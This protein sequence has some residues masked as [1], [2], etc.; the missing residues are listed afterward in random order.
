MDDKKLNQKDQ[1]EKEGKSSE[2]SNK[3][4]RKK[5]LWSILAVVLV[6][7]AGAS[8][9]YFTY[10]RNYFTTDN[11]KVTAKMYTITPYTSGEL[12]EWKIQEGQKV[13]KHE[14]LGRQASLPYIVS[15]IDGT[16]V[17]NN[18]TEGQIVSPGTALAVVADTGNMYIG[19]NIEETEIMKVK[20]GQEVDVKIDAY[21]GRTFPG[22]IEEIDQ[23]TQ[24]YLSNPTSF[25]T[26]GTYTKVTQLIP[27]KVVIENKENLPLTFGMNATVKIH[28]RDKVTQNTPENKSTQEIAAGS[29]LEYSSFIEAADQFEISPDVSGK[30]LSVAVELGQKVNKGDVL[31]KLDSADLAL[32]VQQAAEAAA[33]ARLAYNDAAATYSRLQTLYDAG[34]IAKVDLDNARTRMETAKAQLNSAAT[35]LQIVQ[36]KLNDCTVTAPISG[37]IASLK[38]AEGDMVSPQM[39]AMTLIDAK[40]VIV[41]I[42]VTET[43][44]SRVKIGTKVQ[45]DVQ[46]INASAEGKVVSIAPASDSETGMFPVE[47]RFDNAKGI[48]KP[49]M[50]AN[51]KLLL[52]PVN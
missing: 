27:V 11:A 3:K 30:V 52:D 2:G 8:F 42:N 7:A 46:A 49:G 29:G 25:S 14:I 18:V 10:S 34:A 1:Q 5:I 37:E 6:I 31:F 48:F 36:K 43:N 35:A 24:T 13:A 28:L 21:P 4:L 51:V 44:I 47:I 32:Q 45:I 15:P 12:L 17:K 20:T 39:P 16:I 33:P 41:H 23:T 38:I 19:V 40:E 9:Y 50:A 22:V 26:S